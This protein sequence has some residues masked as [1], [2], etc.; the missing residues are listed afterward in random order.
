MQSQKY[1]YSYSEAVNFS[2]HLSL[3]AYLYVRLHKYY[4]TIAWA[5]QE[6]GIPN[7][8]PI[9][10]LSCSIALTMISLGQAKTT[11]WN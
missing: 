10:S 4:N 2:V 5:S 9:A 6:R 3:R 8:Y 1:T 7:F 11:R